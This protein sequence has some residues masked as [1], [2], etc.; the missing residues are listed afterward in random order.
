MLNEIFSGIITLRELQSFFFETL[1]MIPITYY[2]ARGD[3]RTDNYGNLQVAIDDANKRGLRYLYVPYGKYLYRGELINRKGLI[4]C[5]NPKAEIV[6]ART[7][8]CIPIHQ[9]GVCEYGCLKYGNC[10]GGGNTPNPEFSDKLQANNGESYFDTLDRWIGY[11]GYIVYLYMSSKI[12]LGDSFNSL[13]LPKL[14][15]TFTLDTIRNTIEQIKFSDGSYIEGA[16]DYIKYVN[17]G[18]EN[19][20]LYAKNSDNMFERQLRIS[21]MYDTAFHLVSTDTTITVTEMPETTYFVGGLMKAIYNGMYA[22]AE[23]GWV[24]DEATDVPTQNP[25]QPNPDYDDVILPPSL[26]DFWSEEE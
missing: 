26:E 24:K 10:A 3:N 7:G 6:N 20:Y 25:T 21:Y 22:W 23:T 2:G 8:E 12:N 18:G 17:A 19:I 1:G 9:F 15:T 13:R 11:P 5:G 16:Y 14:L 4:F